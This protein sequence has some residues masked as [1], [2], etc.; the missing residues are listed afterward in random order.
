MALITIDPFR[1]FERLAQRAW[2][3]VDAARGGGI[4]MDAYR[5]GDAFL[6]QFDLPGVDEDSVEVSVDNHVLTVRAERSR[7]DSEARLLV[8]ERPVGV[9]ERQVVLGDNLDLEDIVADLSNG[10]LTLSIPMSAHAQPRR[11]EISRIGRTHEL[12]G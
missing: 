2:G 10:V 6:L 5:K 11:I 3:A 12:V 4:P 9:C 1:E 7:L 8:A